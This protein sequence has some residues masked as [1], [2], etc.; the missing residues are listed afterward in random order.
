MCMYVKRWMVCHADICP[1]T[2]VLKLLF[3]FHYKPESCIN[4]HFGTIKIYFYLLH[5]ILFYITTIIVFIIIT[6]YYYTNGL[7]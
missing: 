1:Q 4:C 6:H 2:S 5:I 7:K 3:F